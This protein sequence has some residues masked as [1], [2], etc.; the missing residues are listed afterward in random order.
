MIKPKYRYEI[1]EETNSGISARFDTSSGIEA[2]ELIR[3][4]ADHVQRQDDE[5]TI[6]I[7]KVK[8]E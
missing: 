5:T 4:L 8:N 6:I 2:E 7:K 1:R 3:N